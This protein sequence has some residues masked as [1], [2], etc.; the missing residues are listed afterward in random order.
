LQSATQYPAASTQHSKTVVG[1]PGPRCLV[2]PT[3]DPGPGTKEH[4]LKPEIFLSSKI[5]LK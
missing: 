5:S 2:V 1:S 3:K 4:F